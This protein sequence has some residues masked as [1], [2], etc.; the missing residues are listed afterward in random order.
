MD[1][2]EAGNLHSPQAQNRYSYVL[3]NPLK[4]IDTTGMAAVD[5]CSGLYCSGYITSTAPSDSSDN[6]SVTAFLDFAS[7][8]YF[9]GGGFGNA[10]SSD[11]LF[12]QMRYDSNNP[13]YQLGQRIGDGAAIPAGLAEALLGGGGEVVGVSFDL[14]G[15]GAL[16]GVPINI[17]SGAAVVQGGTASALGFVHFSMGTHKGGDGIRRKPGSLGKFKGTDAL[18]RENKMVRDVAVEL[19]LNAS[20]AEELHREIGG[21][22]LSFN[23][24]L[25]VGREMFR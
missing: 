12:G 11:F 22:G 23:E 25:E 18:R 19:K 3:E 15:A 7:Y 8:L 4:Y 14:T 16:L 10:F 5:D 6:S 24:I 13:G 9:V 17:I 20:Q 2:A 1:P 21:Q